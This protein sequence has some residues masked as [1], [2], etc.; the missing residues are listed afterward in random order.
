MS[1]RNLGEEAKRMK[2]RQTES[3]N[4]GGR[5]V[6]TFLRWEG[7]QKMSHASGTLRIGEHGDRGKEQEN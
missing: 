2:G 7:I 1:Q 6:A 3:K 4:G 5:A